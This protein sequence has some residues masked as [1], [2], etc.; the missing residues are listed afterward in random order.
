MGEQI[1]SNSASNANGRELD[2]AIKLVTG[3]SGFDGFQFNPVNLVRAVNFF[4]GLGF[5]YSLELLQKLAELG[6]G[7]RFNPE[8]ILLVARALYLPERSQDPLPDLVL[9]KPDIDEPE[10]SSVWPIFP[11][12]LVHDLPLLLVGGYLV[13][14][15]GPTS[16]GYLDWCAKHGCLRSHPLRPGDNPLAAVDRFL[17]SQIWQEHGGS[18]YHNGML[19]IQAL[20]GLPKSIQANEEQMQALLSS[21]KPTDYWINLREREDRLRLYWDSGLLA[22]QFRN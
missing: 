16:R 18:S 15:E 12:Y 6:A 1:R 20:R 14:G 10:D 7:S 22:Y 21:S 3:L 9:G 19:R 11:L 4:H 8:N 13:G 17:S 5:K 2:R